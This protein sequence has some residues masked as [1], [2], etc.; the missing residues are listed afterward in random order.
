[1][2]LK[3]SFLNGRKHDGERRLPFFHRFPDV[4]QT[5]TNTVNMVENSTKL[6]LTLEILTP[7][8]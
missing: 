5:S 7:F 4:L 3:K 1:M 2:L 6:L 8:G